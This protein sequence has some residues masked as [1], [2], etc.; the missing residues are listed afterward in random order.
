MLTLFCRIFVVGQQSL[1]P[2]TGSCYMS[3]SLLYIVTFSHHQHPLICETEMLDILK[4][5]ALSSFNEASPNSMSS[6]RILA[7]F[8]FPFSNSGNQDTGC[9]KVRSFE[10][11][12]VKKSTQET[13]HKGLY[14]DN[15]DPKEHIGEGNSYLYIFSQMIVISPYH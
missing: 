3:S 7:G 1:L 9:A 13:G 4:I 2:W 10:I 14:D 15:T 6:R 5:H 11:H 8:L 12:P